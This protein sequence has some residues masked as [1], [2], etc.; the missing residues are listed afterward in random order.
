MLKTTLSLCLL[1]SLFSL[2]RASEIYVTPEGAGQKDGAAWDSAY[3]ATSLAEFVGNLK[4]GDT[5]LLGSGE[6]AK[7]AL[8]IKARGT[9]EAP[10][11]IRGVDRG[12]GLPKLT[13]TWTIDAPAK[14]ATAIRL[15]DQASYVTLEHLRIDGYRTG[16]LADATGN[17]EG[18]THL[19][20]HDVDV[21]HCQFG[22]YLNDCDN[23]LIQDCDLVR[24]SK[25]G[26]RLNQGCDQVTFR[27]CL[28]DCSQA[29]VQ[30]EEHTELLPFGFNVNSG[31][32]PNTHIMFE[33][34]TAANNMMPLQK[35]SY[36]NGDGF[37]VEGNT[38]NVTFLRCRG[39][40]NQDAGY[41]LKVENVRLKDCIALANGRQ[42][43]IWTT[44]TLDNCYLGYGGTGLW[45]NGG[46]ITATGCTFYG[47]G[48]ATMTDDKA[49]HKITLTRC[50]IANCQ[51]TKR[52]TAS[53]GGVALEET[54][55]IPPQEKSPPADKSATRE[56]PPWDGTGK[57]PVPAEVPG[58]GYLS[59]VKPETR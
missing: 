53:G 11:T 9:A 14:G 52:Q 27:Q 36:K 16:I 5:L 31:G 1:L 7:L 24:Y 6:Y 26:F 2:V 28:A 29:D 51:T 22:F 45:C 19:S 37:V 35:N 56:V 23:L 55:V 43:R 46:P 48:V 54:E 39:I 57:P 3:D 18:R 42:M 44:A 25:H 47:L 21:Q 38:Q 49:K 20:F 10:I 34:C 32:R 50:L 59:V 33:D 12:S 30:W 8:E 40:R 41:D 15:S 58:Q 13:S 4:P 17:G